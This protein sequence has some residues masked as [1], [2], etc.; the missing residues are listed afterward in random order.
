MRGVHIATALLAGVWLISSP[1]ATQDGKSK[2]RAPEITPE[3]QRSIDAGLQWLLKHQNR[4]GSWGCGEP[5]TPPSAGITGLCILAFMADGHAPDRGKHREQVK[6]A[7]DWL[8]KRSTKSGECTGPYITE[9]SNYFDHACSMLAL[10]T[11][12]GM[13]PEK[14]N[15]IREVLRAGKKWLL[16]HQMSDGGWTRYGGQSDPAVTAFVWLAFRAMQSAGIEVEASHATLEKYAKSKAA[17]T[18]NAG[19][20]LAGTQY[21]NDVCGWL[22]I[23]YG[24]GK[25]ET[26]DVK[27]W[28]EKILNSY[29]TRQKPNPV[30]EWDF[31][32]CWLLTQA[33]LHY[34]NTH[35]QKWYPIC[36][37]YYLELQL[38][39][40]SWN[41]INCVAC[42]AFSTALAIGILT[43]PYR[44]LP[45]LQ[46]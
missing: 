33:F 34:E 14:D 18:Q 13:Y 41:I 1:V 21:I 17:L 8:L 39:D 37:K 40:G 2:V 43:V 31:V 20:G 38:K 26:D 16:Q 28:T 36:A 10:A 6:K 29:L 35:F 27:R 32:G 4:D 24:V 15:K 9:M 5:P 19:Q 46:Q 45:Y 7:V 11:C 23:Q 3:I 42:K 30:S 25:A 22:R 44:L 12:Y